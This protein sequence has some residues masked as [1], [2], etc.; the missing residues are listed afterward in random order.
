MLVTDFD[1]GRLE[2]GN[3]NRSKMFNR[4]GASKT[5]VSDITISLCC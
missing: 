5:A 3:F 2:C 1:N 4:S